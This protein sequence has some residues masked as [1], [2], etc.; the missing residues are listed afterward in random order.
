MKM[1]GK[2][3][4]VLSNPVRGRDAE[5]NDWYDNVHVPDVLKVPGVT[6]GRR[7]KVLDGTWS[8]AAIY[9]LDTNDPATLMRELELRV[10]SGEI[11]ISDALDA[12]SLKACVIEPLGS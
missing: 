8:Y 4:L 9:D 2:Q 10:A 12:A 3:L 7:F 1:A 11:G 6:G 5:F